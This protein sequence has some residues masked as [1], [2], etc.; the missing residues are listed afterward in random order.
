MHEKLDS[1]SKD[2][3]GEAPKKTV[4]NLVYNELR[5]SLMIG[6]FA[7][8]DRI[9]LRSLAQEMGTSM[10]P[11]REAVNR[12]IAERAFEVLP[13]R[14]ICVPPMPREKFN[15]ITHWRIQLETTATRDA[16]ANA[17]PDLIKKIESINDEMIEAFKSDAREEVLSCNYAFHFAIYEAAGSS[18]LLPMIESLWLQVGP[19]TYYSMPSPKDLWN[20]K[21][22]RQIIDALKDADADAAGKAMEKDITN[23][24]DYLKERG[25]DNTTKLRR[26]MR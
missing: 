26:I 18:V 16:C 24:A 17:T 20:A 22:H 11:V 21:F 4:Q 7:P 2:Q 5:R 1:K 9:S 3:N 25:Y 12:L 8:G 13:N 10:M 23:T 15:E 6:A 19:F 14:S